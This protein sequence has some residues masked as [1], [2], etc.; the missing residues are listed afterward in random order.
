M[1]IVF[2]N[3]IQRSF[4]FIIQQ[5]SFIQS[6]PHMT[7]RGE[8]SS[9]L[10]YKLTKIVAIFSCS[11]SVN[12]SMLEIFL[13]VKVLLGPLL[14]RGD[15]HSPLSSEDK[16]LSVRF[17]STSFNR[18]PPTPGYTMYAHSDQTIRLLY[19]HRRVEGW[20]WDTATVNISLKLY[21]FW[22]SHPVGTRLTNLPTV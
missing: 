20:S 2:Y 7:W 21:R 15:W 10:N 12:P 18:C 6:A 1:V 13:I 11:S 4:S 22:T 17:R 5:E 8:A 16:P 9:G 19:T 3:N 14:F